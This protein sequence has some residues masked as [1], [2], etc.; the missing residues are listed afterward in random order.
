MHEISPTTI[1]DLIDR[2]RGVIDEWHTGG[3]EFFDFDPPGDDA[4]TDAALLAYHNYEGWHYESW[5]RKTEAEEIA[6]ATRKTFIHNHGRNAAIERIDAAFYA[7]QR[8]G[9]E[10][11]SETPGTVLDRISIIYLKMKYC[12]PSDSDRYDALGK[13]LEF[14]SQC[15][16]RLCE[17]LLEGK[18]Q[19][20][21]IEKVKHFVQ[22]EVLP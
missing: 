2:I 15:V 1:R 9:G 11:Y 7:A 19:I 8:R 10:Y 6:A 12:D 13:Q 18:K 22:E 3:A 16:T 21:R 20:I 17:D 4:E 14:L 5:M